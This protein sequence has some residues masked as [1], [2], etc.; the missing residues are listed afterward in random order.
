MSRGYACA[1]SSDS[2]AFGLTSMISAGLRAFSVSLRSR[3]AAICCLRSA[4][5]WAR[6]R[7]CQSFARTCRRN[8]WYS[9]SSVQR[10]SP[11]V[12]IV[13][14]PAMKAVYGSSTSLAPLA[15]SNSGPM[16][17]SRLP[18]MTRMR[19]PAR[20]H[21]EIA[22]STVRL[23]GSSASSSPAQYSKRSPRI[24]SSPARAAA[25]R[26]N[27]KKTRLISG[28]VSERCRSEMNR[29][30]IRALDDLR[31][32]DDDVLDRHVA[33]E[34]ALAGLHALDLVD[35]VPALD[36]LAEHAIAPALGGGLAVIQ[37]GV[38]LHVDEELAR[39]RV[40][41]AGARHGDG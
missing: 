40:R 21:P 34:A 16:R 19:V 17:K 11:W 20:A 8:A 12:S 31:L 36:H 32:L 27:S 6:K 29:T 41:I 1:R 28:R 23:N 35:H 4:S 26:R 22:S 5:D 14:R 2:T 25:P 10:A 39:R 30:V 7:S 13:V 3:S 38:V 24:H 9:W 15:A 33:V 37:E 18:C